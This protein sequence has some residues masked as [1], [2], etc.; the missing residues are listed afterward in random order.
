MLGIDNAPE[1]CRPSGV[2]RRSRELHDQSV[3]LS[4]ECSAG[5]NTLPRRVK[6]G[7]VA[8]SQAST[9]KTGKPIYNTPGVIPNGSG[10][11]DHP[12]TSG[13]WTTIQR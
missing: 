12:S 5:A 10:G 9:P 6:N 7:L 2:S 8:A 1:F 13:E 3:V 4:E 11:G